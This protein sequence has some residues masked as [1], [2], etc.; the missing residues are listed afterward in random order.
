MPKIP[1]PLTES[2]VQKAKPNPN[3]SICLSDGNGLFLLIKPSGAKLWKMQYI[4]PDGRRRTLSFGPLSQISL[5]EARN[6]RAEALAILKA[7]GDPALKKGGAG[8]N[9]ALFKDI[10][11]KWLEIKREIWSEYHFED[12]SS[13][14]ELHVLPRLGNLSIKDVDRVTIQTVL[15][16]LAAAK[17]LATLKK[18]KG[19]ISSI[20]QF[21]P[22][23]LNIIDWTKQIGRQ[24]YPAKVV[25]NRPCLTRPDDI[26]KLLK[27]IILY[28]D[29]GFVTALAMKFSA[30]TMARPGEIRHAEWV[31][32]DE[33]ETLWRIPADKMK[34]K[35]P[36]IVPLSKQTLAVIEE[37][38]P[39]TGHG[40]YLFP[41][42]RS[43]TRP[44]SKKTVL[45]ALRRSGYPK[46][47]MCAHGF[48]GMASSLLN[49]V[50]WNRDW[51]ERQLA[52]VDSNSV[53]AAYNHTDFLL[54]R[55]KMMDW[56]GDYLDALEQDVSP[57]P[58]PII[59]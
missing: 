4:A 26:A 38:R 35:R 24:Q 55:R 48:R 31:E 8:K 56:W 17:K 10:T 27:N 7:G 49:E 37:L 11:S 2:Q 43:A 15:D 12:C 53:R 29:R 19:I 9:L 33:N 16:P 45:Y 6:R 40:K 47:E 41:S 1:K 52:H 58:L 50:G 59:G 54:G 21:A 57:P 23:E 18:I 44:M 39:I 3:K 22:P 28:R 34:E 20:L 46:S 25:N 14:L 5:T 32:I 36:H 13:K 42:T 51:I 30:L